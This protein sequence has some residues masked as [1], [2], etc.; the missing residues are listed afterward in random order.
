E[1]DALTGIFG[2]EPDRSHVIKTSRSVIYAAPHLAKD[3]MIIPFEDI[4]PRRKIMHI[5]GADILSNQFDPDTWPLTAV[6]GDVPEGT[7][8]SDLPVS[9]RDA[10]KLTNMVL[11]GVTAL[12]RGTA[13]YMDLDPLYPGSLIR[14]PLVN[15]D[16]LHINNEVPFAAVCD[17]TDHY[18]GLV[19]CSKPSYM[20][21]LEDIGTDVLELD[22][23]HFQDYGDDAVYL[24]LDMYNE[25]NMPYY[26]GGHNKEEAQK[27]LL[28][29]HNGNRFA[30]LGCNAKE[31]GYAVASDTRPGAVHCDI[32]LMK[33]QISDLR[34]EGIIPIVTFQHLEVFQVKPVDVVRADFEAVRDAGA[35]IVSGSQSH[36]PMEFDVSGTNFVHY[37]LG[38]LFFDQA[39][40]LPET[41]EAFIDMHVFYDGRYI[42]TELL[43]IR[44]TNLALCRYMEEDDRA[45]LLERIFEVS[46]IEG[47]SR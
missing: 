17:I 5:D 38:N 28:I 44:F 15:A 25:A 6:I 7:D 13:A 34:R 16:I 2:T 33:Q 26:G 36:I 14:E 45:Q 42:N 47:L 35:V 37:G 4:E 29:T 32:D 27:P 43:T 30:F 39:F 12:V 41:A 21:L 40:F 10:S 23:D 19:F 9:N 11:T 46:E 24:T 8:I 18:S 3:W 1:I 20:K 22:G 31:I